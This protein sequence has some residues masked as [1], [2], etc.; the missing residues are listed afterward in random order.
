MWNF[1]CSH[2]DWS[3]WP[4]VQALTLPCL[5]SRAFLGSQANM[6]ILRVRKTLEAVIWKSWM[7]P[8]FIPRG[9]EQPG[10]AGQ[11]QWHYLLISVRGLGFSVMAEKTC[12]T[13]RERFNQEYCWKS[14]KTNKWKI[15][16]SR[17]F[18]TTIAWVSQ[19]QD[20]EFNIFYPGIN[21]WSETKWKDDF[22]LC[23]SCFYFPVLQENIFSC[24][25][26]FSSCFYATTH[27]PWVCL[28][29]KY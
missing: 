27:Q 23:L 18:V 26:W 7:C 17:H 8:D 16:N 15:V 9:S 25:V 4:E 14:S 5:S 21:I 19:N 20:R 11:N 6:S 3:L 28:L 12:N 29:K 10:T 13:R 1:T 2:C 22:C 24:S